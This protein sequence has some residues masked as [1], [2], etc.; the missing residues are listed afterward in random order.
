M[1]RINKF[2]EFTLNLALVFLLAVSLFVVKAAEEYGSEWTVS[3]DA[4]DLQVSDVQPGG[5]GTITWKT[6]REGNLDG[7]GEITDPANYYNAVTIPVSNYDVAT[8]YLCVKYE[9][10]FP[11]KEHNVTVFAQYEGG[12]DDQG[13]DYEAGIVLTGWSENWNVKH[14]KTS[15]DGKDYFNINI[16]NY[17][18][19]KTVSAIILNF[20]Y[21]GDKT[22]EKE[23]K[24]LGLA[25]VN[26][27]STTPEF[28]T[29]PKLPSIDQPIIKDEEQGPAP[30]FTFEGHPDHAACTIENNVVTMAGSKS[31]IQTNVSNVDLSNDVYISI[32]V[33]NPIKNLDIFANT[34]S[35]SSARL[36]YKV[37]GQV[38]NMGTFADHN[39][40]ERTLVEYTEL[41]GSTIITIKA[42]ELLATLGITELTKVLV[43]LRGSSGDV[44][45]IMNFAITTDG[46]HGFLE[47]D[48]PEAPTFT[49]E[50]HPDHAACTIENNVVTM[51]GSKSMIQTNV[52]NVDLSNDVYISIQ[53][54]NP[55]KNL[56]IFANTYSESSARLAY[57]V[58]GQVANMGTFADHNDD[59][60]TL[61]EYT[62][63]EG[64]TIITIKADELLATLGI[65]ELT[66][67]LVW[68]RGSSG[69]V[70]EIY[71]FAITTDGQHGFGE[72]TDQ[73]G[74]GG[75]TPEQPEGI[76]IEGQKTIDLAVSNWNT[77]I[78]DLVIIPI[79]PFAGL[80]FSV[81]AGE[82]V[83]YNNTFDSADP[84]VLEV[85]LSKF[86]TL[87]QLT[88]VLVGNGY[89]DF[90][91]V[92]LGRTPSVSFIVN[93]ADYFTSCDQISEGSYQLH[94]VRNETAGYP[95]LSAIVQ[96]WN[97]TYDVLCIDVKSIE[98][99]TLLGI[100]ANGDY[101]DGF[102]H[103]D[104]DDFLP[105]G[106]YHR[107]Y[108]NISSLS[109]ITIY[110]NVS[111]IATEGYT[112]ASTFDLGIHLL[113]SSDL[114]S[115]EI[116]FAQTEY[117]F[118][119]D[120]TEKL[121]AVNDQQYGEISYEYVKDGKA[122]S[123]P[124]DAGTYTVTAKFAGS[125]THRPA[126]A[127]TTV[128]INKANIT[129]PELTPAINGNI[130]KIES[131]FA[132]EYKLSQEAEWA[133]LGSL[134]LDPLTEYTLIVRAK[135]TENNFASDE[136]TITF[137]TGK[138]IG[139]VPEVTATAEG[140][141]I[142]FSATEGIEYKLSADGEWADLATLT[143]LAYETEYTIIIRA[144]ETETTSAS[145]EHTLYVTTGEAPHVHNKTDWK[146]ND[147]LHWKECDGCSEKF[148]EG[149]HNF[150]E[151]SVAQEA[152]T[153]AAG[154]KER[155]CSDCNYV[156]TATI[157]MLEPAPQPE[158][159]P[160]SCN[161]SIVMTNV[162]MSLSVLGLAVVYFRKRK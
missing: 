55:I 107:T 72:V 141:T 130:V 123:A 100:Q 41:E 122:Y 61:V 79:T 66:K 64:S 17:T 16:S 59:E 103:W 68:L 162:V 158:P 87:E 139:V 4:I 1:K 15:V 124:V 150:G 46:Q 146:H 81:K 119:Y 52:S 161:S 113:K 147:Q 45:E 85:N 49:F 12:T 148:D 42:D 93:N 127:T 153:E 58:Q 23:M 110:V 92:E 8:G 75:E 145:D 14:Y 69:D 73:P 62:E 2:A 96:N 154:R 33:S 21:E 128:V 54:S 91:T 84:T 11:M 43:W 29:D 50:G 138:L 71:N 80:E 136:T 133:D 53:V 101:L 98:G 44:C 63:L 83:L 137:T 143:D 104:S 115:A 106:E 129:L 108:F 22:V 118:D 155:T 95:T 160:S 76:L 67:V 102:N 126:T 109:T 74:G 116:S 20:N 99:I 140:N 132:L 32:Q 31:M 111:S 86:A 36:A 51:A 7:S 121:V 10:N 35:E 30:T 28:V 97:Q 156:Q 37:Q 151:W 70:C 89:V 144:K 65:T 114:E 125:R 56:D 88:F 18:E 5:V 105:V 26:S 120:G 159:E 152:T 48:E 157:P 94:V 149:S 9:A 25:F 82:E 135:E 60:R 112:Y 38:A 24:I 57:K 47:K 90:G 117:T 34:Y 142:K 19:S 134:E 13:N 3:P 27:A 77:A 78:N 6:V 131:P 40:D 39:D